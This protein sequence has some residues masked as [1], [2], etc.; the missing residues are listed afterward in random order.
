MTPVTVYVFLYFRAR[1]FDFFDVHIDF[2]CVVY[3]TIA[4]VVHTLAFVLTRTCLNLTF[5]SQ[6]HPTT[7]SVHFPVSSLLSPKKHFNNTTNPYIFSR[8]L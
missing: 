3:E 8:S 7:P 1:F 4:T 6:S 5:M 2:C